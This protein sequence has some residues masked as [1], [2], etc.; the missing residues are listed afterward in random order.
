MPCPPSLN[1][2]ISTVN[3]NICQKDWKPRPRMEKKFYEFSIRN[4]TAS[5]GDVV[6]PNLLSYYLLNNP[7]CVVQYLT[8]PLLSCYYSVRVMKKLHVII[9]ITSAPRLPL[10][11]VTE[12][13]IKCLSFYCYNTD[14][15]F[16]LPLYY[17]STSPSINAIF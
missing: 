13:Q 15:E 1:Q 10:I 3:N 14:F 11:K 16:S 9:H 4:S 6:T 2:N 17:T 5:S 12:Q 8:P 7:S